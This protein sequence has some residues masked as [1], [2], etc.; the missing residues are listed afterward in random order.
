MRQLRW[1]TS[2]FALVFAIGC[3]S[4]DTSGTNPVPS[5]GG[6]KRIIILTNG[7]SPFWDAA[8]YGL[9]QAEKDLNLKEVGLTAILENS[10]A[11]PQGQLD[12]LRQFASQS[13][14]AGLGVSAIDAANA[15]IANE[16]RAFMKKGIPV[17][18]VDSDVDRDTMRDARVAF[19]GTDNLVGGRELGKCAKGLR[20]DGG[21]YVTFVG[22]T[23]AQNAV[24]RIKGFAEGAGPKFKHVD[25][26]ED[27]TDRTKARD[28]VRNAI[29]NHP[30]LKVLVGIWSYN[31]PAIVD[32]VKEMNKRTAFTIVTFDAEPLAIQQGIS[33]GYIDAMVVQNP[34]QMGYQ[35]VRLLKALAQKDEKTIKEILPNLGKP[36][37]DIYDTGLKVVVPDE[38]S[39][40]KADMFSPKTEFLKFSDFQTWLTKYNLT[41]S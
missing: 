37:G 32:V 18:T 36:D 8:G 33:K 23:G 39:P 20:P 25:D 3:G 24:E 13:D 35:G 14:I 16:L 5:A 7:N 22:R 27:G 6:E 19:V 15:S 11:S 40:L 12:R 10:E 29:R 4:N 9:Q 38:G 34:Y 1:I 26:M 41:G 2:L 31:A 21:E 28:N 17:I 30:D